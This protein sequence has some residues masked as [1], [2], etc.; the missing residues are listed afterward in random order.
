MSFK[1]FISFCFV[2]AERKLGIGNHLNK[3]IAYIYIY[4]YIM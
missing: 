4:S 1:Y 2:D 3:Q